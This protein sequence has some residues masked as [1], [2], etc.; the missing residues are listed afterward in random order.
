[1][2]NT[3][4]TEVTTQFYFIDQNNSGGSWD[5]DEGA[6]VSSEV[7]VEAISASHAADRLRDILEYG[8]TGYYGSGSCPCCGE[9]WSYWIKD[10]HV[11]DLN[12]LLT[13]PMDNFTRG[14][15]DKDL[16]YKGFIHYLDGRIVPYGPRA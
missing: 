15:S 5:Y 12:K 9:R 7:V 14:L 13:D 3:A 8:V 1:M 11:V 4:P 16:A 2:T 10:Y 6:G